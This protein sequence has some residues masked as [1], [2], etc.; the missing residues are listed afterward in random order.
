MERR[1][2]TSLVANATQAERQLRRNIRNAYCFSTVPELQWV[3]RL[4]V[5]ANRSAFEIACF[6]ELIEEAKEELK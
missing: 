6:D 1:T 3:R 2:I 4:R 5:Q